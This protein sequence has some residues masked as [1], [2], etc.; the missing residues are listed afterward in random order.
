MEISR[1]SVKELSL[2]LPSYIPNDILLILQPYVPPLCRHCSTFSHSTVGIISRFSTPADISEEIRHYAVLISD[3]IFEFLI[4]RNSD[5]LQELKATVVKSLLSESVYIWKREKFLENVAVSTQVKKVF[6]EKNLNSA[7]VMFAGMSVVGGSAA[8]IGI[9]A[10]L[11]PVATVLG[12]TTLGWLAV[13]SGLMAAPAAPVLVPVLLGLAAGGVVVE[14]GRRGYSLIKDK[15]ATSY[16][17]DDTK[18]SP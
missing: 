12:S 7:R 17:D 10:A 5:D 8:G 16:L 1:A 4:Y 15:V 11:T 14:A 2:V 3:N 18:E 13:G 6:D 9:A